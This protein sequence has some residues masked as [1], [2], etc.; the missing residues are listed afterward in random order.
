MLDDAEY[1]ILNTFLYQDMLA[2]WMQRRQFQHPNILP[3]LGVV[4]NSRFSGAVCIFPWRERGN[5]RHYIR[6]ATP[7]LDVGQ[8][9]KLVGL[10][11]RTLYIGC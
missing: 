10:V 2:A 1:L 11:F 7:Q 4:D 3:L 6:N 8:R 9:M 5:M